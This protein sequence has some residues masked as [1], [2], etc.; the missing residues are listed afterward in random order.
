MIRIK[1]LT[2][3]SNDDPLLTNINL[4]INPGEIH[5][6]T[7]PKFSGKSALAHTITGHPGIVIKKGSIHYRTD[8]LNQLPT[9]D[10]VNKGMF[11]SFQTPSDFEDITNW[12]LFKLFFEGS[13]SE[14]VDLE[15]KYASYCELL[16]LGEV[17][18]DRFI[19]QSEMS[20]SQFKRN[21][22]LFMM[23]KSHEFIILDEIDDGLTA[24]EIVKTGSMLSEYITINQKTCLII[25]RNQELL[26]IIKPTHVHIMSDGEILMSGGPDLYKRIVEDEQSEFS[27]STKR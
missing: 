23:L 27:T 5:A 12:E 17:H 26:D 24:E 11:I 4:H 8:K 7:G 20:V 2:V 1:N 10:R 6:V 16:D 9:E 15:L 18:G 25:S 13:P 14:L 3:T 19:N 22:L 21:E